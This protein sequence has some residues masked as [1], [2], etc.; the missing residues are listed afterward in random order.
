MNT[1]VTGA[2]GMVGANLVRMLLA[3][4]DRVK[5]LTY[6]DTRPLDGMDVERVCC[7]LLDPS[8][9]RVLL[10]GAETVYHLASVITLRSRR[11]VLAE[12]VNAEGARIVAEACL[13]CGV[14]R[15][16]HFSSIHAFSPHPIHEPVVE[17][18]PLCGDDHPFPYDRSKSRGQRSVL[19]LVRQGLDAVIVHPTGILGPGDFAPSQAG[20]ALLDIYFG[21]TRVLVAGGFNWVDV[22]DVC[23]GAIAAEERGGKGENYILSGHHVSVTEMGRA[24]SKLAGRRAPRFVV[25]LWVMRSAAPLAEGWASLRGRE[26]RFS[27]FT[28]HTLAH[29]QAV[30]HDKATGALGYHP[31]PF[32]K[33]LEDVFEWFAAAGMLGRRAAPCGQ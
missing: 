27:K 22:R 18:R 1:V 6:G 17:T 25:P 23:A 13:R 32:S 15:M 16:V 33:T 29:H 12:R 11:N 30:S 21:R 9:M 4:G 10:R 31:R 8:A 19:E 24:V 28:L 2:N 5:V 14:R 26:P 20:R 3:R 7:D